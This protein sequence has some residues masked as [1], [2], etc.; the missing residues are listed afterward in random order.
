MT[1]DE[2]TD[3]LVKERLA[4][5]RIKYLDGNLAGEYAYVLGQFSVMLSTAVTIAVRESPQAARRYLEDLLRESPKGR[6]DQTVSLEKTGR[7][8]Y[9][10]S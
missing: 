1:N 5:A 8:G 2:I 7:M 6:A 4:D 9:G 10:G 3:K